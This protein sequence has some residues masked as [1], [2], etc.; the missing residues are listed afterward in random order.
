LSA[1]APEFW[2][3]SLMYVLPDNPDLLL[4]A[5]AIEADALNMRNMV[6]QTCTN[7]ETRVECQNSAEIAFREKIGSIPGVRFVSG[8]FGPDGRQRCTLDLSSGE[9]N[10]PSLN[11]AYPFNHP[12]THLE[13]NAWGQLAV[14]LSVQAAGN[15]T[16]C[17]IV[18]TDSEYTLTALGLKYAL[19]PLVSAAAGADSSQVLG[20]IAFCFDTQFGPRVADA[21]LAQ[22]LGPK[23]ADVKIADFGLNVGFVKYALDHG[24]AVDARDAT[25]QTTPLIELVRALPMNRLGDDVLEIA[26]T[27]LDHEADVNARDWQEMTALSRLMN[28]DATDLTSSRIVQL[29]QLLLAH[30]ADVN[31][32]DFLGWTPLRSL[33]YSTLDLTKTPLFDPDP[34]LVLAKLLIDHGAAVTSAEVSVAQDKGLSACVALLQAHQASPQHP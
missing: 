24:A 32:K 4:P 22:G 3:V 18:D 5:K 33:M 13:P 27:L 10:D 16:A 19:L 31:V 20:S 1:V 34:Q 7:P 17:D 15:A 29:T 25:E 2:T 8:Y 9:A 6:L 23:Y 12:F 11:G 28:I 14:R 26:Q 30:G 21:L